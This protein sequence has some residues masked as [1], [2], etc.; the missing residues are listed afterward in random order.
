MLSHKIDHRVDRDKLLRDCLLGLDSPTL[1]RRA[2]V[3]GVTEQADGD[4][5]ERSE[6]WLLGLDSN[7]QPSG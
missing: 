3:R 4:K 5:T 2:A 7:Q 6:V 1:A